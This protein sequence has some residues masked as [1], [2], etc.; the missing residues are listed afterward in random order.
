MRDWN[1]SGSTPPSSGE[2]VP[3][4]LSSPRPSVM[5]G[6]RCPFQL[7]VFHARGESRT[8]VPLTVVCL[9]FTAGQSPAPLEV[10]LTLQGLPVT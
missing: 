10:G 8:S 2:P 3:H 4:L 6:G 7:P 1:G 9:T 5:V